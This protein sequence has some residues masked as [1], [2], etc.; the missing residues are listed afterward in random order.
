M[1]Q[2]LRKYSRSWFIALAI[3]AI[4]VVFIFW[5]AGTFRSPQLQEAAEVNG[6]PIL[7]T[8][9]TRQ[10]QELVKQY[11]ERTGGELTEEMVKAMHVKEMALNRL[12]DETLLLQAGEHLGLKVSN[13][14][15][16]EEIR[17]YPFFQTDGKFDEKRYLWLL[18]RNRISPGDFE[19]QERQRLLLRKVVDEVTSFAKVSDLE[20][21][22]YYRLGKEAVAVS[23]LELSP[24]RVMAKQNPGDAEVARYYQEHQA[25]FRQP[26]R[27][28]VNYLVFRPRDF[29]DRVQVSGAEAADYLSENYE[30]FS[31]PKVIRARQL[32]LELPAKAGPAEKQQ[33]AKQ[34]QELQEKAMAGEDFAQLAQAH[35]QDAASKTKGGDLGLVS[36]GQHPPE[37]DKVA[38]AL[39]PGTVGRA[40]TPQGIYL[41]KLEE[42][43]EREQVPDAQALASKRLQGDRAKNLARE[44]AQQARGEWSGGPVPE[45]AKK[46]GVTPKETQLIALQDPV[47]GLGV[48]P[49]FNQAALK[50]KPKEI[51]KV[52]D[53][54]DGFAVLQGVEHQDDHLPPLEKIKDQVRLTVQKEMAKKAT[55]QEAARLLAELRK[56]KPLAQV[57]AQA[58]LTVKDSGYFTRFQGF[59][60]QAGASEATTAA[61]QLSAQH[62]YPAQPLAVKDGYY[63]LAFKGR[64]PPDQAEM[65]RELDQIR[66]QFLTQKRQMIFASWLESERQ[67]AKIKVYEIP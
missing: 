38:F 63:L 66:S 58:G 26:A 6:T 41:I 21:E 14:E 44:A 32:F 17:N 59:L 24:E 28:R 35:S 62:P 40:A 61:F 52:V 10:F 65:H 57:A 31:R 33:V 3:G 36:R 7:L 4:V 15:L 12:I 27:A 60:D 43:K 29:L 5:G 19:Q 49:S 51:S 42:I 37:W 67:R 2:W 47:P 30:E 13:V 20:L 50:L 53:L 11:Q 34:A 16:R 56:G 55:E 46:Y 25:A 64:R 48:L 22:E 54:P 18:S 1:L 23:Y 8:A 45:V 9:Y 39:K